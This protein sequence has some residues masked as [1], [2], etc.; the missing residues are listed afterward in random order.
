MV[1]REDFV[2]YETDKRFIT[3]TQLRSC[4]TPLHF[5]NKKYFADIMA[6]EEEE[7]GKVKDKDKEKKF[8]MLGDSYHTMI[9]EPELFKSRFVVLRQSLLPHPKLNYTDKDNREY[10]RIFTEVAAEQNKKILTE[11]QYEML[12]GMRKS[13]LTK[14]PNIYKE[15]LDRENG[16]IEHSVYV[17]SLFDEFGEMCEIIRLENKEHMAEFE[18]KRALFLMVR[19]D[20]YQIKNPYLV[21]LKSTTSVHPDRFE[22]EVYNLEHYLVAAMTLDI[23]SCEYNVDFSDFFFLAQEKYRPYMTM[24]FHC[25]KDMVAYG[26]DYYRFRLSKVFQSQQKGEYLGYEIDRRYEAGGIKGVAEI[27]LPRYKRNRSTWNF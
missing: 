4:R 3:P 12:F 15:M 8:Y 27:S 19:P 7:T 1:F 2:K 20:Y 6:A 14:F 16:F 9:L 25:D 26:R 13:L 10:K 23:L 5:Y 11:A 17:V 18:N 22:E 24:I 21:D